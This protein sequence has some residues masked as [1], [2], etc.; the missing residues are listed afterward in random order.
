MDFLLD[1]SQSA[2]FKWL[3]RN[4]GCAGKSVYLNELISE[5]KQPSQLS[6][7]TEGAAKVSMRMGSSSQMGARPNHPGRFN[8]YRFNRGSDSIL[9]AS[10]L[11]NGMATE[12]PIT[13]NKLEK[14][15]HMRQASYRFFLLPLFLVLACAGAFAQANSEV[16]GIV[17]DQTGA[18]V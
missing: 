7:Q 13:S 5:R 1:N 3:G 17:T 15:G 18:V 16:T 6:A 9:T 14:E 2:R 11:R 10:R 4:S 12:E 8:G